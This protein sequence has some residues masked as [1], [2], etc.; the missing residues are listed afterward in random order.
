M[1][2][3]KRLL[4][5]NTITIVIPFAIT[6]IA[7]LIFIFVSSKIFN[8][9]VRYDNFKKFIYIKT[10]L[11]DISNDIWN[12]K[13]SDI[14]RPEFKQYLLKK[15][16]NING[17]LIILKNNAVTF[18][19]KDVNK[20]D[21]EK[22]LLED[23]S[24]DQDKLVVIDTIDYMVEVA[25]IEFKD[26]A[27]GRVILL[28]PSFNYSDILGKLIAFIFVVFFITFVGVNIFM[29][30]LLSKRIVK[31]LSI[32]KTAVG[33][34]SKGDLNVE[35]TEVGDTEI[36]DLCADF[37]KMRIQLKDTTRLKKKYDDNRTMLVSSISHDLK[38]PITSI[39]G[40]VKGILDGVANTPD[41]VEFYLKTVYSKS[42]QLDVMIDDLLLYS[43]LDL[44]QIPFNFEK[45][46]I[47]DYF[48]YCINES[49]LE[50]EK[51]NI[52]IFVKNDLV[53]LKYVKIDRERFMRVI[54][55]IIDNSRKYMDKQ[56]GEIIILLRETNSSIIIEIRDNGSGID[57]S[58][59]NKI[60]DRFY[61][62]D[63]AR[64][65]ANGSGL[66]LAIAKQIVEGH[67]GTIWA[68][69]HGNKGISILIS[70]GKIS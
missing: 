59:F 53:G 35:V 61:R 6:I 60:F 36:R 33:E 14:E 39:K 34:I 57:E 51:F 24:K 66:G 40:Y 68:V 58:D 55:N 28:V 11:S 29:S 70:L 25:P 44:S 20:I 32:L 12:L 62:A 7:A 49:T 52:K 26:K 63:A 38:T 45:T 21:I 31:P 4:L 27:Q 69:S 16:S 15:V 17:Y 9:Q 43:K 2:I 22:C 48:N 47:I 10:Q 42:E 18:A 23:K 54:L 3:K 19:S 41:K 5:S 65:E 64:S 1:N 56:Q 37:E 46:D 13:S 67:S 8:K 30:Y 50:L